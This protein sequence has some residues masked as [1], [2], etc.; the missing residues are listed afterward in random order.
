[1]TPARLPGLD[2]AVLDRTRRWTG[3]YRRRPGRATPHKLAL[4]EPELSEPLPGGKITVWR[5]RVH[6]ASQY[7]YQAGAIT[8][9]RRG[10]FA[11]TDRGRALPPPEEVPVNRETASLLGARSSSQPLSSPPSSASHA[12]PR[13]ARHRTL[14][15]QC[16][17]ARCELLE[18]NG[19]PFRVRAV[20]CYG[21]QRNSQSVHLL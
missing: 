4:T 20:S 1:M 12:S 7:L 9:S 13:A 3:A 16:W 5:S 18:P 14:V 6:W 17:L 15:A 8:R 19:E 2:G 11:I 21:W 10:V